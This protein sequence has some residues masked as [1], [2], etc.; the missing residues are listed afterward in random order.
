VWSNG[1]TGNIA[2]GL[3]A[4]AYAVTVTDSKGCSV[5]GAVTLSDPPKFTIQLPAADTVKLGQQITLSPSY[6]NGNAVSWNWTP[7][8]Y[9]SCA[10][11]QVTTTGPY[12]NYT[13][14]VVAATDKGCLDTATIFIWVSPEHTV[15]IPNVFTPNGDGLN[16][17]FEVFG[18]KEAWKQFSASIY[19]RWGEKVYETDDMNFKW[20]GIYKGKLLKPGV[21][22]YTIKVIYLDNFSEK[23]FK[24]S[25]TLVR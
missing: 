24:G 18:N 23:L 9:L 1:N 16:D 19:D 12:Y 21:F 15:F 5:T 20:D 7:A 25:V 2:S 11:C 22:V 6:T 4:G 8:D 14:S 13:Y 17:Y 3:P 10:T